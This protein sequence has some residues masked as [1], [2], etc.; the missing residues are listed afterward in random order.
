[1]KT[2]L[3]AALSVASILA[4]G[5]PV[6]AHHGNAAYDESKEVVLKNA[7]V[8]K[9]V[10]AN[11]HCIISFD[12]KDDKGNLV[13]WNSELGSP[14]AISLVG[15]TKTSVGPGDVVTIYIHQAKTRNPVGRI[16]RIVLPDG[17]SLPKY[18]D[19]V[20]PYRNSGNSSY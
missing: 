5:F 16:S 2:W 10:W 8:T 17:T 18:A 12:V 19:G 9:F 7:T 15:F 14:S 11:P 20:S 6:S 1:M 3:V 13:H 4:A